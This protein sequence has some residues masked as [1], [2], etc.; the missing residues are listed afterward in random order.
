MVW[1]LMHSSQCL[2]VRM[3]AL[4]T[5]GKRTEADEQLVVLSEEKQVLQHEVDR[6][7]K[8]IRELK[9]AEGKVRND[10]TNFFCPKCKTI[11]LH[12]Y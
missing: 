5:T 4:Q 12:I 3:C 8:K 10:G 6:L 11:C 9:A 1:S 7:K 2:I